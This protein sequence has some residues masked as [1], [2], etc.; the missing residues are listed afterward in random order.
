MRSSAN[1]QRVGRLGRS[2]HRPALQVG[3]PVLIMH[4][5]WAIAPG[6]SVAQDGSVDPPVSLFTPL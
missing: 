2:S 3:S 4:G 6:A 1:S 5:L